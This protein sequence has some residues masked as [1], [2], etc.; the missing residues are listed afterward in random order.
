MVRSA[1][2]KAVDFVPMLRGWTDAM[3]G[4]LER[5]AVQMDTGDYTTG[6]VSNLAMQTSAFHNFFDAAHEQG[7]SPELIA[8]LYPLMQRRLLEGGGAEDVAGLV[9]L[10]NTR[11]TTG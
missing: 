1:G 6:V 4:F 8:P 3:G 9:E 10:L 2:I 5:A 11:R 7:V